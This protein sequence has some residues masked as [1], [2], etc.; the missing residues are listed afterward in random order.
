M[1]H[2]KPAGH[3]R[4]RTGHHSPPVYLV[5]VQVGSQWT[6]ECMARLA[7]IFGL[8]PPERHAPHITL[9]GPFTLDKGCDIRVLLEDP[10]LRSPG[11]SSFSAI[12][13]GAL[14][15]RGRKGYAAVIRAAPGDPLA[16]LAAA[17]RDS[18]LPHTRTCTWIDQIAGQRIFHVSTGF[19][20]RRRK[21]EEIVEF[22]DTLPAG[23]RNAEGMRCMAGTT[24]DSFRLEV[25]R[26]GTLM[27]AFDFPTGT[28]IGR[29]AA[30]REDRWEKTLESFRQKSGYQIDR[31]SFSEE[32]AA[33]VISDL[34][35]GHANIIT[36][37]SRPFPDAATMDSVLIQNWNFRVRPTDT[38]YFL[39]DLAYGRNAGP[40][41]RYLSLLAG[42]IHIVAGNH[43]SGLEHAS[44][45]MEITWR[46]RRFLMVHDPAEAPPEYPGFV[47]HGHLHN[48][49]PGEYPFLNMPGRRVNV[50]AEMVG[51]VPLSLDEL[52]D[53][54]ETSPGDAQFPTLND[55]RRKLN[56]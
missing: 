14:V 3:R 15:L 7:T 21:A 27:D 24:L 32:Q 55:A 11:F 46:S 34:H 47:G 38:V 26:R 9:F 12:L 18:L 4:R 23:R 50:S 8:L 36:Y 43:D 19:G 22:L 41:A 5:T 53:I 45:S 17:V 28:W 42:V 25:I 37:T 1:P 48:N 31:P 39:G 40:A 29:P 44:G 16:L 49:Q 35:L 52:V 2:Q 33:F 30:F 51:Y 13:G 6:R 54:I 20:L 10:L 56:R